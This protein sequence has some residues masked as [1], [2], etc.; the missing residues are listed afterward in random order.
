MIKMHKRVR[1]K[2]WFSSFG[3]KRLHRHYFKGLNYLV[4]ERSDQALEVLLQIP[5]I[6]QESYEIQMVLANL[7]RQ[8][9]E[10][11]RAISLH[12]RLLA[13]G[14]LSAKYRAMANMELGKDYLAAG[15]LDRAEKVLLVAAESQVIK[16]ECL[17]LL[18]EL[19]Q[20]EKSWLQAIQVSMQLQ[21]CGA[22]RN[23]LNLSHYYC[24]LSEEFIRKDNSQAA[25]THLRKA[26]EFDAGCVRA[27]LMLAK[28]AFS[29]AEHE[30]SIHYLQR[31][32]Q[33]NIDYI[34]EILGMLFLN[35]QAL[36]DMHVFKR[37]LSSWL[38]SEL[39][40]DNMYVLADFLRREPAAAAVGYQLLVPYFA[41]RPNYF[42]IE[43]ILEEA[44][45]DARMA[46]Q[47]KLRL[48]QQ[49][50]VTLLQDVKRYVC[51]GCG[52]ELSDHY[53]LCPSCHHWSTMKISYKF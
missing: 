19:Y 12:Q 49:H 30:K 32:S 21:S 29:A 37:D 13:R 52:F 36:G 42:Y 25:Q 40:V 14:E 22:E 44:H 53:W 18:Q 38:R 31:V 23:N 45:Q 50:M 46:V 9:G 7:F 6:D 26:L 5:K 17:L 1:L 27:Y 2:K 33:I 10:M 28:I 39:S 41:S 16:T 47:K 34:S 35:Y 48:A 51:C 15:V 43:C 4:N 8:R 24:E 20:R 3:Y 11:G